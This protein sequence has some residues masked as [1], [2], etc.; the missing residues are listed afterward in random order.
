MTTETKIK[1][2]S[3]M[4]QSMWDIDEKVEAAINVIFDLDADKLPS[5]DVFIPYLNTLDQYDDFS[6]FEFYTQSFAIRKVYL[7]RAFVLYTDELMDSI[8][9]FCNSRNLNVVH[10]LCCGTGLMSHWMKKYGIPL[11]KAVDNKSWT[12]YKMRDKFLPIVH[13]EHAASFVRRNR[14]ADMFILSWPYMDPLAKMIWK[15]MRPGQ[16]LF[17]IGEDW[18]GCTA[19]D[20]FFSSVEG[21]EILNDEHFN[22]ISDSFL[23]FKGLHDR[24]RLFKK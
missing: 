21:R 9:D 14:S 5:K 13:K 4:H 23:Q 12:Y 10:D 24:P 2:K 16:L 11:K 20:R 3:P 19:D 15:H 17:Y 8:R 1:A 7:D 18:G 22:K 6:S